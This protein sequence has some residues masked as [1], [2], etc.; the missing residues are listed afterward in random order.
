MTSLD[1]ALIR[2]ADRIAVLGPCGAGK[3]TLTRALADRLDLPAVHLDAEYWQP[4]WVEPD[5]GWFDG[6]I[7]ALHARP[8]W[9][10]DGNFTTWLP[11]RLDRT[12]VAILLD[13]PRRVH[14]WRVLRRIAGSYGRVRPDMAPGCPE[15]IDVEF[16]RYTWTHRREQLPPILAALAAR[17]DVP[18][19]T[20]RHPRAAARLLRRL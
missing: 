8:R 10:I 13:Y 2:R 9:V 11:R 18:V 7:A 14:M 5:R 19:I 12:D 15:Q 1:P 17:P 6:H 16:L 3:S 20:L 4:G